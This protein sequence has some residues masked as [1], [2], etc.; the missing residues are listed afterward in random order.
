[1]GHRDHPDARRHPG[2]PRAAD[3]AIPDDRAARRVDHRDL[4]RRRRAD[5]GKHDD[6]DHRAAAQGHRPPPLLLVLLVVRRHRHHHGHV[7]AG[8][9]SG[10]R[11][12]PGAEQAAGGDA[13]A[14]AGGP[15]TG[16]PGRQGDAELPSVRRP[17]F[18]EREARCGRPVRLYR[19]QA[20][21]SAR[22]RERRRRHAGVRIAICDADLGRS[23]EAQQLRADDGGHQ[24]RRHR[25]ERAGLRRSD[26]CAAGA[27]GADVERD[28]LGR[29]APDQPRRVRRDQPEEQRRRLDRAA[30]RRRARRDRGGELPVHVAMER[31]ARVRHRHQARTGRQRARHGHGRESAGHRDRQAVSAR[32]EGDLSP[33]TPLPSCACRS[34]R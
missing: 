32:R 14:A 8:H 21:G 6:P 17:L 27:Q 29:V 18:G 16:H 9:R 19:F 31:Q 22:A 26:R 4:S 24:R 23:A 11:A 28:R 3:L 7:R 20:A 10:H 2:D 25:A 15:A 13:A 33:T 34:T 12:G 1:M 30:A 5:A